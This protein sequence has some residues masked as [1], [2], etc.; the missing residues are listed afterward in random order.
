M[1]LATRT[2]RWEGFASIED[3]VNHIAGGVLMGFGGVTALGCTIGQG[4]T[5]YV[6]AGAGIR[7]RVAVD[8]RRVRGGTEI[9]ILARRDRRLGEVAR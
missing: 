3:L 4:L 8:H 7:Y 2:F 6:D 9:P 5:G 1:A